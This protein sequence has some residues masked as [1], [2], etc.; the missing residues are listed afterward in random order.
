MKNI[1]VI[2]WWDSSEHDVSLKSAEN[3]I[4]TLEAISEENNYKVF[5]IILSWKKRTFTD[6]NWAS[7]EM[8]KN[9]FSLTLNGDK[10]YFDFAYII[11]H[12]TPWEDWRLQ[13]YLDMMHIPYSTWWVLNTS[14]WFNK[15]VS[16]SVLAP[17][18]VLSP[19]GLLI[20]KDEHI[21]E[22]YIIENLGLPLFVKPNE[23]WSSFW[24]TKVKDREMLKDAIKKAFIEC[25]EVLI[26][27][28]IGW[29]EFTCGILSY[30]GKIITLPITEIKTNNEFFDY[31]AKYLWL[32]EEITPADIDDNLKH[33]I[34]D[35]STI[36]YKKMNCRGIVRI[37]YIYDDKNLYF[38]EI[39]LTPWMTK[40][41]LV[42]QQ[43]KVGWYYL[44]EII[45]SQI[46]E[47]CNW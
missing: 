29:R 10:I 44:S 12:W 18:G 21:D 8:D 7:F 1:A 14:I 40:A 39:N 16:K 22:Q 35:T 47:S 3:I 5:P 9:D 32:S 31:N 28:C 37:D 46:E 24:V 15:A 11:I 20:S 38:L 13:W 17:Y 34:Q 23:W 26:E 19:K 30:N 6:K 43:L 33:L 42:P 4:L 41:S 2:A 27:S 45:K 36:I 25:N